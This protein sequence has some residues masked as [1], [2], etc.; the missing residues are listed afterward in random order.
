MMIIDVHPAF[1]WGYSYFWWLF[2]RTAWCSK[3]HWP[4]TFGNLM[5][6]TLQIL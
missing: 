3:L 4:P 2:A 5:E 1:F 6:A